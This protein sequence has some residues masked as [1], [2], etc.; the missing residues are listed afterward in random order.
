MGVA[1]DNLE[2]MVYNFRTKGEICQKTEAIVFSVNEGISTKPKIFKNVEDIKDGKKLAPLLHF[3][4]IITTG[5]FPNVISN[6]NFVYFVTF[7][8]HWLI[9]KLLYTSIC[10]I[11][12]FLLI[13]GYFDSFIVE[14]YILIVF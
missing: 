7:T 5:I 1:K 12:I 10:I 9:L 4:N 14:Q 13:V 2:T 11:D 6:Q 3:F 8:Q